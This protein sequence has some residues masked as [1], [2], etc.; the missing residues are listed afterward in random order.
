L[1]EKTISVVT[2]CYNEEQNVLLLYNQVREVF[3]TLGRFKYEHIFIDNASTDRTV[4][5]LTAMAL[6]DPNVKV[7][8]NS[9][10]FGQLSSPMYA[11]LQARGDAVI[12]MV[13]DLQDPPAMIVDLIRE[14]ESGAMCVVGI[15]RTSKEA[16]LM[17]WLRK[18]YY[19][20]VERLSPIETIQNF[21]GFGLYDRKV[22]EIVRQFG[23][24]YPFFR[25]MVA[26]IGLPTVKLLYDQPK[27]KFGITSNNWYSL[28]EVGMHGIIS[29]SK[30][31]LRLA[32]LGGFVGALLSL[33]VAFI[34]FV[35]K[36]LFWNTFSMGIA[37]IVSG[38]FFVQ[39]LVLIALGII[40]E[41][42][43]ATYTQVKA[44]P[45]AIERLRLNF[46]SGLGEPRE[47]PV[48]LS[49]R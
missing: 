14:W 44:R 28:Y 13:A 20:T 1:S 25:G 31:P 15:K 22:M 3:K 2:P 32:V 39:S 12:S 33:V 27:R 21:T 6:Q 37:P 11:M 17:F 42:V 47:T 30:V 19:K 4:P 29:F 41:Y 9:R 49:D 34:Y 36:L 26:E 18:Q 40:G 7:I 5:I 43:G 16:S 38:L 48:Q 24:A 45:L 23:D 46:E 8:V 10:N 35:A